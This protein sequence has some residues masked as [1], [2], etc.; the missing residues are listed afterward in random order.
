LRQQIR[1]KQ[2]ELVGSTIK[3]SSDKKK[4][5]RTN[6]IEDSERP[7]K[8]EYCE[9]KTTIEKTSPGSNRKHNRSANSQKRFESQLPLKKGKDKSTSKKKITTS[10]QQCPKDKLKSQKIFS[11]ND[12]Y[13]R[14][15]NK[16][17]ADR[18]RPNATR[19]NEKRPNSS[20]EH[21]HFQSHEHHAR[22]EL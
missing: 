4:H 1:L 11:F 15:S 13:F 12:M 9:K 18:K 21:R 7:L 16:P 22:Y 5:R 3:E 10:K 6:S 14:A 17:I 20:K 8:T 2:H 19:I